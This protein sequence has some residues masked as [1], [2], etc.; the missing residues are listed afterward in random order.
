MK[1]VLFFFLLLSL[2]LTAVSQTA[3]FSYRSNTEGQFKI[4]YSGDDV[5][6]SEQIGDYNHTFTE[7]VLQ[8]SKGALYLEV[9]TSSGKWTFYFGKTEDDHIDFKSFDM[10]TVNQLGGSP[11]RYHKKRFPENL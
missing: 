5:T 1:K 10:I 7:K 11:L 6:V 8:R 3:T 4:T 2:S 9:F